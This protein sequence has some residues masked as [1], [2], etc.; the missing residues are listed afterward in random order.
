MAYELEP[1]Y[2][3]IGNAITRGFG[4]L[5]DELSRMQSAIVAIDGPAAIDWPGFV[6][7]LGAELERRN[8]AH[9]LIDARVRLAAFAEIVRRTE[10]SA[11]RDD[12]VFAMRFGGRLQ[13][14]L[15]AE[16]T[17]IEPQDGVLTIVFGPG[18]AL[19]CDGA[20]WY[21]DLPKRLALRAVEEGR[22]ANLGQPDGAAGTARRLLFV[23]WPVED[24]HR[25]ALAG[26]W[27]RY[28]DASD[29]AAP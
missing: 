19:A 16:S 15:A 24:Q 23:D 11:L 1:R 20:V 4:P 5:A 9:R 14:L 6:A 29:P 21:V 3:V 26:R 28:V 2:P 8:V 27:S 13:D 18:S 17:R 25:R 12:P 7:Q 22:A 10:S